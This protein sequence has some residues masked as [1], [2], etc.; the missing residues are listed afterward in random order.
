MI[1]Q[2]TLRSMSDEELKD[3]LDR[4]MAV[5]AGLNSSDPDM[6]EGFRYAEAEIGKHAGDYG[7]ILDDL[8]RERLRRLDADPDWTPFARADV[9]I[10]QFFT[11]EAEERFRVLGVKSGKTMEEMRAI[12][13]TSMEDEHYIN[14]RYLVA[15]RRTPASDGEGGVIEMV[16]LSVKRHDQQP[17]RR[18]WADMQRIKNELLGTNCEAVELYPKEGRLVDTANQYHLWGVNSGTF[19]WPIGWNEG[20][21]TMDEDEAPG[22]GQ[23]RPHHQGEP[24]AV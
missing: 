15:I 13:L 3:K 12:Y 14:S 10:R 11:S 17:L 1:N 7:A 5:V 18:H 16:H 20:Q 2:T 4:V 6:A 21:V 23:S 9:D 24:N 19:Q 8:Y 22:V